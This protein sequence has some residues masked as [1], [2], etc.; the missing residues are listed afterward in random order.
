MLWILKYLPKNHVSWLA[1]Q[2]MHWSLP[3]GLRTQSLKW[4]VKAFNIRL[5]EAERPL[6]SYSSIGDLFIRKLKAGI[7]PLA[8][9]QVLHPA[10]SVLSQIGPIKQGQMWQ[11]K[12]QAYRIHDILQ[13]K[14]KSKNFDGGI[15]ATYYLCPTDYHRVHSPVTGEITSVTHIPGTLWPVFKKSVDNIKNLFGVNE[16]IVVYLQTDLGEV[17]VV[18]V[19]A[20]NVGKIELTFDQEIYSQDFVTSAKAPREKIYPKPIETQ[21]GD[22]LG[23]FRMGSTVVVFYPSNYS[24]VIPLE[25]WI[26]KAGQ[27]V[28]YGQALS[29][30]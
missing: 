7:R 9:A 18:F 30:V 2:L 6:E 16:R 10:D 19:G 11:V 17:A 25:E 29:R 22:E 13:D 14:D 1:G 5:E 28:L 15:F 20:L 8:Q 3:G 12:H 27:S 23:F 24:S 21:A 4:F 26:S